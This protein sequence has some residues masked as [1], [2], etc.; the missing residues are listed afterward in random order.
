MCLS[1]SRDD[2]IMAAGHH[3]GFISL[4]NIE[5]ELRFAHPLT[6]H[7]RKVTSVAFPYT[8]EQPTLISGSTDGRIVLWDLNKAMQAQT[9]ETNEAINALTLTF[10]D[11][12]YSIH[13][14]GLCYQ[15]S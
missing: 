3:N 12:L 11:T 14:S 10:S 13:N 8:T 4:F 1:F 5:K 7:S 2:R 9:W 15:I 6:G